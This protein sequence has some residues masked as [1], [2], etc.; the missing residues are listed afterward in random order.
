MALLNFLADPTVVVDKEGVFLAVN[1]AVENLT[2]LSKKALLGKKYSEMN[3]LTPEIK[4]RMAENLRKRM[5][6]MHIEPYEISLTDKDGQTRYFELKAKRIDY[7]GQEAN[8]VI[9]RDITRR[10]ENLRR[11]KE[12]AEKMEELVNEKVK[13]IHESEEKYHELINKMND[14]VWVISLDG[15]FIDVNDAAVRT[16]GYSREELLRIGPADIDGSLTREQIRN[17]IKNMPADR[18]QVFET[19]HITK[20]G[21]EIPVEISS[22]LMTYQGKQA[23]LSIA[24]DITERKKA[25][26]KL[27]ASER[28]YRRLYEELKKT[29]DALKRERD[30]LEAVTENVGAGL[31]IIS[32]DYRI[33]WVNRYLRRYNPGCEGKICYSTFNHLTHVCPDCGVRKI[34]E[35]GVSLDRHEYAFTGIDG[36]PMWAE[37]IA[38][39]LKDA[40]GNVI[41]ALELSVDITEKKLLQNKLKEYSE[42]LEQLVEERTRQLRQ[43]QAKLVKAERLA[44]IGELA[45]IIGHDLRNPL[46]GIMGAA[47]YLKTKCAPELGAKG[48]EMLETIE[49]AIS[50]SNKIINDLLE[51]SKDL[52]LEYTGVDPKALLQKALSTI[53]VPK[54]IRVVDATDSLLKFKADEEKMREAFTRIIQNA[55]DAMPKGGTLKVT[56]RK[57][58][59][60][61]EIAFR[62]TGTGMSKETLS[63][64]KGGTPLFTTKAKGMGFGLPVCRRIVEAHGGKIHVKSTVRR[65]TIVTVTIPAKP[66]QK[67]EGASKWLFNG[68]APLP[69]AVAQNASNELKGK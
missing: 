7:F 61:I 64:I 30:T 68:Y 19:T 41:A 46:T 1:D 10:K 31:G 55:I 43:T 3:F 34:F 44:A 59:G 65:G 28:E 60:K 67:D 24:R 54:K 48:K 37:L 62:D 38:T 39:P 33:L 8:V 56:S 11:L 35:E 13:Q 47:Y 2:G 58:R 32:R 66:K 17:L 15:K 29:E 42:K 23:I 6:G 63:K 49:K 18:I 36:R 45:A 25:E 52:K 5:Q 57:V 4:A 50:C 22:S 26:A 14:T 16:L 21:K 9:L 20:D 53:E 12:Y 69:I 40:E 27:L 51:Y